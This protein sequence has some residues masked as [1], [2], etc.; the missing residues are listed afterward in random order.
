[1]IQIFWK[2]YNDCMDTRYDQNLSFYFYRTKLIIYEKLYDMDAF[3]KFVKYRTLCKV[4][5]QKQK[6]KLCLSVFQVK[7]Q[8]IIQNELK[9]F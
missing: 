5:C 9:L 8:N 2:G 1:M 7:F 4:F 3:V 6:R